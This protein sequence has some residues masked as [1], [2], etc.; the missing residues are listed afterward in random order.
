MTVPPHPLTLTVAPYDAGVPLLRAAGELDHD[1]AGELLTAVARQLAARPVPPAV[2]LDLSGVTVCDSMG[3]S[4]LIMV[5]RQAA[6]AG[7]PL[8]LD[9]VS[10]VLGRLLDL[11]GTRAYLTACPVTG[12]GEEHPGTG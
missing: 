1:T 6:S 9:E 11:T 4:A 12:R 2:H 8:L 10:P 7:V 5:R 3:L